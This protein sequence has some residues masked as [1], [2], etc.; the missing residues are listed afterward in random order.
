MIFHAEGPYVAAD[1]NGTQHAAWDG[2]DW[3]PGTWWPVP[4]MD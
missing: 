4:G 3:Q 2:R 1:P